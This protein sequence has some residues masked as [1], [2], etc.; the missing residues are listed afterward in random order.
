[1]TS[2]ELTIIPAEIQD[3][4]EIADFISMSQVSNRHLDW[5]KSITWLGSQPVLK[6][7][8]KG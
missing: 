5:Q 3:H 2:S 1:M 6:C 4:D 7:Y 8:L